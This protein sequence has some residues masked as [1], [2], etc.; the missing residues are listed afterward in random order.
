[1]KGREVFTECN[2]ADCAYE[3][4]LDDEDVILEK[5]TDDNCNASDHKQG[6]DYHFVAGDIMTRPSTGL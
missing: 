3:Q 4:A 1:M 2:D 6:D 5:F